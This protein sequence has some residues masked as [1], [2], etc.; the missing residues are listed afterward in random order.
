MDLDTSEF[1][2]LVHN[3]IAGDPGALQGLLLLNY[4][5]IENWILPR[6]GGELA[7]HMEAEDLIQEVLVDVYRGIGT[8]KH[9]D[10]TS[11]VA[12][13]RRI[14]NNRLIDAV[15]RIRRQKRSG[16]FKRVH[17][18]Q[19][20]AQEA[21]SEIWDWLCEEENPPDRPARLEEAR[22]ALQ[23]CL[24]ALQPDQREAVVAHYFEHRDTSEVAERM[25]RTPGAVRELI[26]R[27]RENLK[28]LLGA[29]SVWLSNH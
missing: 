25:E 15:R 5:I 1:D 18:Q 23:V 16:R 4:S 12:W 22:E 20:P 3:A 21:L 14:A 27:A 6:F 7:S 28:G 29:A 9:T 13:L 11:F 10:H 17:P 8:Y 19:Q 2:R 26:R 24:A